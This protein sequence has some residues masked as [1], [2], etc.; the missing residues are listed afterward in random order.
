[1]LHSQKILIHL[2]VFDRFHCQLQRINDRRQP[3]SIQYPIMDKRHE[4]QMLSEEGEETPKIFILKMST[5]SV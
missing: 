1:M 4:G 5:H 3:Q 2:S